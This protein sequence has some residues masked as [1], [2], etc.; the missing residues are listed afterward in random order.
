MKQWKGCI[1]SHHGIL[2]LKI[3]DSTGRWV[4][5]SVELKDS[6]INRLIAADRL[7]EVRE[8]LL[9]GEGA[10]L[11]LGPL[12][13]RAFT[14]TWLQDRKDQ[15]LSDTKNDEARLRLHV[16]PLLGDILV[17][18]VRPRHLVEMVKRIRALD[19]APRTLRNVYYLVRA[20][21]RDAEIAEVVP[22]G[23][24]PCILTKRQ[25]GKLRDQKNGWRRDAVF[26]R[27][28]LE[29]LISDARL[30][31]DHRVWNALLGLGMLRTGEAAGLRLRHL[32]FDELPLG[33]MSVLTSYD[34]GQTKTETERW[35]PIHPTLRVI[36]AEWLL[37]GWREAFGRI[38][39]PDDLVCPVTPEER[40]GRT[41]PVGV[42]RDRHYA[43]KRFQA[44][45]KLLGLRPRRAHDLRRTGISLT[46]GDGALEGILKWGTHAPGRDVMNLYTS[47]EWE[48]LCAE[49]TKLKISRRQE[50]AV[51]YLRSPASQGNA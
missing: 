4:E 2:H 50:A 14:K 32:V 23:Q 38:P 10:D 33:R 27:D 15:G 24:N 19:R 31:Q 49:V 3:K 28:E 25:L 30:P 44:D 12:T 35:M 36:L 18:E 42:M 46:R 43:W 26:S 51:A 1:T 21:F 48:R 37:S 40:K 16:L 20:L 41:K 5:R 29:R 6:P 39:G 22:L 34:D 47:V 8:S 45:L 13:V 7:A 9:S 11:A 17:A